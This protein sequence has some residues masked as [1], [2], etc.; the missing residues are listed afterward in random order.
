MN[1][2]FR[3]LRL[4]EAVARN[5]SFTRA[6]EELH[7]T[8]PA[9]STQIKQLE[10]EV[11][12]PLFEQMGKKIFLTEAGKEMVA[13]SRAIAQQFRDIE[14]VMDDMK[15]VKRGTLSLA[16]TSTGKYFAPY[17]LAEFIKHHPGTQVHLD[18]TNREELV[19]QLQENIPDMAIMGT[20]PD[21]L[22]LNAQAFMQNP[23]VIIARPDHPLAQTSRI[24]LGRL[25]AENFIL[26]ERGSGTRNAVERFFDQRNVKLNTSMEMSR[27]E[28]VKHA[29]MAGLGLGIVSMHTLE[30]EL[31]LGRIAILSVEGFPIMKEWYLVHRSGKRMTPIVQAFHDF[32]LNEAGRVVTL[33]QP[34]PASRTRRR[35]TRS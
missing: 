2:T 28:A 21:N 31:A 13:F 27:N 1:M 29:V 32:V 9:V 25:V 18:V 22:E 14:S 16:V 20:P 17:L 35:V 7:L 19:A 11:G 10:Q 4:L 8:Q 26:R 30:F 15:G 24:P 12:M 23:L 5:S 3:Q 33:P 34:R 6:S